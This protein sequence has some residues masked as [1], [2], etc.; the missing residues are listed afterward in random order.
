MSILDYVQSFWGPSA[1]SATA[2][3]G[4][5]SAIA[6]FFS[7]STNA[8]Q[9]GSSAQQLGSGVW[10]LSAQV[11]EDMKRGTRY[12]MKVVL[13]GTKATGKSTLLA[14]LTGHPLPPAYTPSAELVASTMRLQGEHTAPHEGVKVDIWEAVEEGRQRSAS[15]SSPNAAA[16]NVPSV[17]LQEALRV[18][19]DARLLDVYANA[20]LTIFLIDPRQRSSWEYAKQE[21]LH[22]PPT[23]CVLYALNFADVTPASTDQ[24]A[25]PVAVTLSEVQTWCARVR[26]ATTGLVHRMLEGRQAAP[27]FSVRPMTAVLSALTG[28]GIM[29]VIRALHVASTLL[30]IAAEEVRVLRLFDL[31]A[32]QQAVIIC[33]DK[34]VSSPPQTSGTAPPLAALNNKGDTKGDGAATHLQRH[35]SLSAGEGLPPSNGVTPTVAAVPTAPLPSSTTATAALRTEHRANASTLPRE[36]H[37]PAGPHAADHGSAAATRGL[38]DAEAMRLFLGSGSSGSNGSRH[39]SRSSSSTASDT[40]PGTHA[41]AAVKPRGGPPSRPAAAEARG[42]VADVSRR[43]TE[44]S[45]AAAGDH[46]NS[47]ASLAT[48]DAPPFSANEGSSATI[49]ATQPTAARPL[50]E[51]VMRELATAMVHDAAAPNDDFFGGDEDAGESDAPHAAAPASVSPA[52]EVLASPVRTAE[53]VSAG[54]S[55]DDQTP[56]TDK[57]SGMRARPLCTQRVVHAAASSTAPGVSST[58]AANGETS[59]PPALQVEVSTILAQM[60]AALAAGVPAHDDRDGADAA[61]EVSADAADV[62]E[63]SSGTGRDSNDVGEKK[64]KKTSSKSHRR[65]KND[66]S[67]RRSHSRHRKHHKEHRGKGADQPQEHGGEDA[68]AEVDGGFE[69]VVL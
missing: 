8:A 60:T 44:A 31:V 67:S 18:A 24:A 50:A 36:P 69:L 32:R 7:A 59:G 13:R 11:R 34:D 41:R 45:A 43:V 1:P 56:A 37:R 55:L 65:S 53:V 58:T 15:S 66:T 14:R 57:G 46:P 38:S 10:P 22:V 64:S 35:S 51:E 21:T 42:A 29:G 25:L 30:R 6:G 9:S 68:A 3:S 28:S 2:S 27:E 40:R 48:D 19:A 63:V 26:R 12:N 5:A 49:S 17:Q 33:D 61:L 16:R 47:V 54:I 23:C 39:S 20:H 62:R 52:D 4:P